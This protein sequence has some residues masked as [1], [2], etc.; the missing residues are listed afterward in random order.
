[1]KRAVILVSTQS[2]C[3]AGSDPW[4]HA[5]LAAVDAVVDQGYALVC[6]VGTTAWELVL[7]R[8][9]SRQAHVLVLWPEGAVPT[10]DPHIWLQHEFGHDSEVEPIA[11]PS[12]AG[13]RTRAFVARDE[14]AF[15]NADRIFP[16]SIRPAGRLEER[17]GKSLERVDRSFEVPFEPESHT[18]AWTKRRP[19]VVDPGLFGAEPTLVHLTRSCDGPWPGERRCDW[20]AELAAGGARGAR[21]DGL[22]TLRRIV[23]EMRVRGSSVRIRGG[24]R[25]VALTASTAEQVV[26]LVRW[27]ARFARYAFEPYGIAVPLAV[28]QDLGALPVTYDDGNHGETDAVFR[29]ARGPGGAWGGAWEGEHEWRIRGDLD[30]HRF[31]PS[32]VRVLTALESDEVPG[33]FAVRSFRFGL[34][35][36]A[37]PKRRL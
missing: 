10:V 22:S 18:P 35:Q 8:A 5:A 34:A 33:P 31:E 11:G 14:A 2:R 32:K 1:M 12:A 7:W 6:S 19:N 24:A 16:V 15:V 17:I 23:G 25:C 20:F 28:A 29:Q 27:R 30:L 26:A 9:L 21:R 4:V 37:R 3:P 36:P 13:S